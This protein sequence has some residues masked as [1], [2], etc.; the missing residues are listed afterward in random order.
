MKI[1]TLT[2]QDFDNYATN[3]KH[4]NIY[5]TSSYAKFMKQNGYNYHYVG[6]INNQ[7]K[8]IGAS[9]LIYRKIYLNYKYAY[10]PRGFLLDFNNYDNVKDI[11]EQ[12]KKLLYKQKFIYF[13][14]DPMITLSTRNNNGDIV[15]YN[16]EANNIINILKDCNY[17][18]K[19]FNVNFE[20]KKSRFDA[21]IK[22]DKSNDELYANLN[23]QTRNKINKA[24]KSGIV[25]YKSDENGIN[26][27]YEFI[28]RKKKYSLEYYQN[29]QKYY[30]KNI[31][32]YL[33]KIE[34][35][36]FVEAAKNAYE[37]ELHNNEL[38]NEKIQNK[39]TKGKD[40]RKFINRKMESDKL[41]NNEQ[42]NLI[43][44]TRIYQEKKEGIIIGGCIVIKQGN[45]RYMYIEGFNQKYREFNPNYLLK[46]ELIKKFNNEHVEEFNINAINGTFKETNKYKGLNEMKLGFSKEG[47]EYIGEFD[48][49]INKFVYKLY[50]RKNKKSSK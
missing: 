2:E 35:I 30:N 38:I 17:I 46:W 10:A 6:F 32:I 39:N 20:N 24:K 44:A 22:L 25:V 34:P 7:N 42:S 40:I 21:I 4:K 9:L 33:A 14:I 1:V 37:K 49:I 41:L 12:L 27:L 8:I 43:R 15:K 28:K 11:T 5:Q 13:T 45:K 19:G 47:T 3:H 48:F 18:H 26:T 50:K 31:E 29:L 23:K 16:E 36:K